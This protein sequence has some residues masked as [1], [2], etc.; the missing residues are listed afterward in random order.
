[1][2]AL[3]WDTEFGCT[4]T[5]CGLGFGG[6]AELVEQ[7]DDT[8]LRKLIAASNG[9]LFLSADRRHLQGLDCKGRVILSLSVQ[10]NFAEQL[11]Q[12]DL[13]VGKIALLGFG[14]FVALGL[15][16]LRRGNE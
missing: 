9:N 6:V 14:G 10:P 2:E 16:V 5:S 7:N 11:A 12:Q 3:D 13:P 1:M 8:S 15:G 4:F